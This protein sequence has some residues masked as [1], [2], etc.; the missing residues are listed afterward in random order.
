MSLE[1]F[2]FLPSILN[3]Y[4][5][6]PFTLKRSLFFCKS[7]ANIFFDWMLIYISLINLFIFW[8][9]ASDWE[10]TVAVLLANLHLLAIMLFYLKRCFKNEKL[11]CPDVHDTVTVFEDKIRPMKV[12]INPFKQQYC[13]AKCKLPCKSPGPAVKVWY[14][15]IF[16]SNSTLS[17]QNFLV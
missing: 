9:Q 6:Y 16:Y 12:C 14:L 5:P 2:F 8:L 10:T 13:P 17:I 15:I 7:K 1:S 11:F 4:V 3:T